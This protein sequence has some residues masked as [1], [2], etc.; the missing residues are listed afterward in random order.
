MVSHA[1]RRLYL[2]VYCPENLSVHIA[3]I[4]LDA[5]NDKDS[6]LVFLVPSK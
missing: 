5:M 2:P 1:L 4:V 3:P 6:I